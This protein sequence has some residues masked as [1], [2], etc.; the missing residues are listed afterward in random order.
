MADWLWTVTPCGQPEAVHT[1]W[2]TLRVAHTAHS[3]DG[4]GGWPCFRQ[5]N[6][7]VFDCQSSNEATQMAFFSA[8]KWPY[9]RL[10]KTGQ[11]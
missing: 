4:D 2:T 1:S 10:T 3:P 7:P 8:N 11:G 9:F 5:T 6:G